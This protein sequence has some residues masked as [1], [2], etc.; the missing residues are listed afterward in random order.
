[1]II[2][3]KRGGA[4]KALVSLI[5][6]TSLARGLQ[7][8]VVSL[9]DEGVYG[10]Y[11]VKKGVSVYTLGLR[12]FWGVF[13]VFARLVKIIRICRPDI[14]HTWMYHADFLGGLAARFEGRSKVVWGVHSFDLKRGGSR[15]TRVI[16]KLCALLSSRVP[17]RIICVAESSKKIHEEIGYDTSKI[18]VIPN[19]FDISQAKVDE[20]VVR[21]VRA[22][23]GVQDN[24][25]V[26]GCVGRFHPAKDHRNF[27]RAAGHLFS[28]GVKARFVMIGPGVDWDNTQLVGWIDAAHIRDRVVLLGE[29]S[30][31]PVLLK[32]FDIFCSSSRTEAFP[33]VVGEAM[34]L[35]RSM[36]VT[37][38]GDSR[39]LAGESAICVKPEDSVA[40]ADAL[41]KM[42]NLPER[43]RELLGRQGR[44]R[45]EKYFTVERNAQ[46][47]VEVYKGVLDSG[48]EFGG[49]RP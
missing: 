31:I 40:L 18:I 47:I 19:G 28:R 21:G 35:G 29:R 30:D 8:M 43:E 25:L 12:N 10:S 39:L 27:V 9:T 32:A 23:W 15:V 34:V 45:I 2:G 17:S 7:H 44:D 20:D 38:V 33:L 5:D 24:E 6:E 48:A 3:L 22:S 42:V 26:I 16:Q 41:E 46:R 37:D 1:M 49:S 14:V 36:V 13:S 4:E 11:L